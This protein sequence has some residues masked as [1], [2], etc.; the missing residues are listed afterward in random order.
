MS[1]PYALGVSTFSR[2][3]CVRG[4][5]LLS[6]D[7]VHWRGCSSNSAFAPFP[8]RLAPIMR[9]SRVLYS[10]VFEHLACSPLHPPFLFG[11]SLPSFSVLMIT[12]L[13]P[14]Y[15]NQTS[16]SLEKNTS[17]SSVRRN[18]GGVFRRDKTITVRN[19]PNKVLPHC[20][21]RSSWSPPQAGA[22]MGWQRS[23]FCNT[24]LILSEV[25]NLDSCIIF[26][27]LF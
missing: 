26:V 15:A 23:R 19:G 6:P 5:H 3:P 22:G 25:D 9:R 4:G 21:K 8:K 13:A 7:A 1:T 10:K 2:R 20:L 14:T 18:N 27:P 24:P 17:G 16:Y 11:F 12:C